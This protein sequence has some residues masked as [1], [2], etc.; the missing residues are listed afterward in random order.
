M[1]CLQF[2]EFLK[3]NSGLFVLLL[4]NLIRLGFMCEFYFMFNSKML[5]IGLSPG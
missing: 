3:I 1:E 4:T 2:V 5:D